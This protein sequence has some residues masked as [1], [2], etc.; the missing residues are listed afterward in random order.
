ML[1]FTI[2]QQLKGS[3]E[4]SRNIKNFLQPSLSGT[5]VGTACFD[6]L[7]STELSYIENGTYT[8]DTGSNTKISKKYIYKLLEAEQTIAIIDEQQNLLF[9]LVFATDAKASAQHQC[10]QDNYIANMHILSSTNNYDSFRLEF[11]VKGPTK[12]YIANTIYKRL[13]G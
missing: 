8:L 5:V 3:W 13:K 7:N 9:K 4:L 2:F 11:K 6:A 12:S 1:A 10:I